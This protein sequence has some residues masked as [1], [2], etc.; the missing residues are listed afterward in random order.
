MS[1]KTKKLGTHVFVFNPDVAPELSLILET[2]MYSEGWDGPINS[3]QKLI[4]GSTSINLPES[5]L[6]P[7]NLRKLADEL[8]YANKATEEGLKQIELYH[9]PDG[10]V[11]TMKVTHGTFDDMIRDC[12]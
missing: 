4:I 10:T 8:E 7:K 6:T 12:N 11:G 2:T 9:N 5:P 3:G 1:T